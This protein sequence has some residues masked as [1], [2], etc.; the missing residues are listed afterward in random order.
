MQHARGKRRS[1][2]LTACGSLVT[3]ENGSDAEVAGQETGSDGPTGWTE[4][5]WEW[6][7]M[8]RAWSRRRVPGDATKGVREKCMG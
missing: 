2:P 5:G 3:S 7:R 4:T 8:L 6:E 1:V